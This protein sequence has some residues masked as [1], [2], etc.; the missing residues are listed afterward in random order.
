M[1]TSTHLGT[2]QRSWH[3]RKVKVRVKVRVR[4]RVRRANQYEKDGK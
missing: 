1:E 2:R 3:T 4:V